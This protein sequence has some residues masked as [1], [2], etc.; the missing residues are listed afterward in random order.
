MKGYSNEL[1]AKLEQQQ[2]ID[3]PGKARQL[4]KERATNG[5]SSQKMMSFRIDADNVA[6]LKE[7]AN[8]GRTVNDALRRWRQVNS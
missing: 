6:Y 8:Q 3:N 5:Q 7:Q 1:A 4:R 2:S